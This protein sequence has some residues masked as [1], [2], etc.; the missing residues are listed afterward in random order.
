MIRSSK[1]VFF[2][3]LR[4]YTRKTTDINKAL[5]I[6]AGCF[7]PDLNIT[8]L[9]MESIRDLLVALS[10]HVCIM[11]HEGLCKALGVM[12]PEIS[13]EYGVSEWVVG[14]IISMMTAVGSLVSKLMSNKTAGCVILC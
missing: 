1:C 10:V 4:I 5:N 8:K 13:M 9:M 14:F 2:S 6:G 11:I 12:I 7:F 3:V